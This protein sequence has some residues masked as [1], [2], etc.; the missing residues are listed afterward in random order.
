MK[1]KLNVLCILGIVLVGCGGGGAPRPGG[2]AGGDAALSVTL[3]ATPGTEGGP[4][5]AFHSV[6]V[7][8]S[9]G[10]KITEK[11]VRTQNADR[12][13][14]FTG[15]P[16]GV[17]RVHA[18]LRAT[19]GGA[20]IGAVDRFY[21]TA[22]IA[23]PMVVAMAQ[24][25]VN[26]EVG[27]AATTL[28][29][30][31]TRPFYAAARD[32]AGDYVYSRSSDWRWSS[33]APAVA[34][35]DAA[36]G[37]V[38]GLAEGTANVTAQYVPKAGLS[39]TTSVSVVSDAVRRSKWTI[40]VY[41]DAASDLYPSSVDNFNQIESIAGNPDVRFV[42]QWKR[43]KSLETAPAYPVFDGTRRYLATYDPTNL[44]SL[45]NPIKSVLVQDLGAS[46]DMGKPQTLRD[47]VLWSKKSYP[48][49][50]Y[51]LVLWSHGTGWYT[52]R[53]AA[54][55][56]VKPRAV[57]GDDATGSEMTLPQLRS[58]LEGTR[59]D[60][61]DF[62]ACLMQSVEG[63]VE[64]AGVADTIVG[65]AEN[66]VYA[67]LPY[68]LAFKRF[69][70]EPDAS[71]LDL[72]K[73]IAD[74]YVT[75]YAG[76]SPELGGLVQLGVV[77]TSKATAL[78]ARLDEFAG[79]LLADPQ[80]GTTLAA[81]RAAARR[82]PAPSGIAYYDPAQLAASVAEKTADPTVRD[83]A[84]ALQAAVRATVR[85]HPQRERAGSERPQR[86]VRPGWLFR[87]LLRLLRRSE[88]GS[89]PL[90]R[91]ACESGEESVTQS[92]IR[93]RS[94]TPLRPIRSRAGAKGT[95]ARAS[96][97]CTSVIASSRVRR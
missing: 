64:F 53:N 23:R 48:A 80:A 50:R 4:A 91:A 33:S 19:E 52:N 31:A 46:V 30:D 16:A 66:T 42:V 6:A 18:G 28:R 89:D 21:D 26:V 70:D 17:L 61:L 41:L 58:A 51:A 57:L 45:N 93:R 27:P 12:R 38:T 81:V 88:I 3:S 2:S 9:D 29:M 25:V 40:M 34:R 92:R 13:V 60:V 84:L 43:A 95:S 7:Y 8:R 20:E 74:A 78:A 24:P 32:A 54:A 75:R 35:A 90:A 87:R 94:V 67:G 56:A 14:D 36:S 83:T 86:R 10:S 65:S 37:A 44:N 63:A 77:D 68:H 59:F 47:F 69:V 72:A 5:G 76:G 73:G 79:A 97:A 15:L 96:A 62:D 82:I 39:G 11:T 71:S 22:D 85:L 55:P 49:D 1:G